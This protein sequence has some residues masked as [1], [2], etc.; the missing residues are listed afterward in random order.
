MQTPTRPGL[1][2]PGRARTRPESSPRFAYTLLRSSPPFKFALH[3]G[4]SGSPPHIYGDYQYPP[5]A[6]PAHACTQAQT[7][8]FLRPHALDRVPR[9]RSPV[10]ASA[11]V[12]P[13]PAYLM[14]LARVFL[15]QRYGCSPKLGPRYP[16]SL[17]HRTTSSS[18]VPLM[19]PDV[20]RNRE[21]ATDGSRGATR[22]G[23]VRGR[24][25]Q[26][27]R[28]NSKGLDFA[29]SLHQVPV[30]TRY[31]WHFSLRFTPRLRNAFRVPARLLSR[32]ARANGDA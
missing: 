15:A 23:W 18:A 19:Q 2:R 28:A 10:D 32:L 16:P 20:Q 27:A 30:H 13:S 1:Q 22:S 24:T 12:R 9:S 3:R 4:W 8:T 25:M 29:R 14:C 6:R 26:Y 11:P 17:I 31:L 21:W 7:K 5:G